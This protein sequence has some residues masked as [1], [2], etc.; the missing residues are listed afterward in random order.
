MDSL[1][2]KTRKKIE[3]YVPSS[4]T[5]N[6]DGLNDYLRPILMGF[7]SVRY[8][9][10]YSRWGKLLFQMQSDLPGWNGKI[11]GQRQELQTVVWVIEAVD[12]DGVTHK[13]QGTSILLR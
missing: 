9:K 1:L 6:G 5:P 8:F 2:V 3:I 11:N 12:V 4:F 13:K 10:V 7:S